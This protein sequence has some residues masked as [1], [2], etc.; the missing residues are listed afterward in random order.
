MGD[1][2]W[3]STYQPA[4]NPAEAKDAVVQRMNVPI[5]NKSVLAAGGLALIVLGIPAAV[6]CSTGADNPVVSVGVDAAGG[7]LP[8]KAQDAKAA[9]STPVAKAK[10]VLKTETILKTETVLKTKTVTAV[11]K[12]VRVTAAP[13]T[14]VVTATP[15]TIVVTTTVVAAPSTIIETRLETVM[16]TET[17]TVQVEQAAAPQRLAD[18]G[19]VYFANCSAARAAGA[20]P[21]MAGDPGYRS[22][23]DRD[24][25]GIACE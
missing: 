13:K 15:K 1:R 22:A 19:S 23:L 25:D 24:G 8:A 2:R 6:A 16:Q 20:A 12:T 10:P 11:P 3:L 14:I 4:A 18:T 5:F 17:V 7:P 21:V 9:V